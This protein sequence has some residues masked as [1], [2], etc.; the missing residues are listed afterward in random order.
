[1]R[2]AGLEWLWRVGSEPRRLARRYFVTSW[3]F[4]AAVLRDLKNGGQAVEP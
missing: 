2:K 3:G 4:L 1:M